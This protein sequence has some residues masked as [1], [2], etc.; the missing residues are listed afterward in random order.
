MTYGTEWLFEEKEEPLLS[1]TTGYVDNLVYYVAA[2]DKI[3]AVL[4]KDFG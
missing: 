2:V 3:H 4:L 1:T